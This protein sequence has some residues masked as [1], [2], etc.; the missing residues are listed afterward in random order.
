MKTYPMLLGVALLSMA[1]A[2]Y[3]Q[4]QP[5]QEHRRPPREAVEAC[6]KKSEG[7]ECSFTGRRQDKIS[8]Q[9]RMGPRGEKMACVP[10]H[11]PDE[12]MGKNKDSQ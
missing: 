5:Q 3:A 6:N 11:R 9:C 8:G 10:T 7:D 1:S 12:G 2:V 4:S